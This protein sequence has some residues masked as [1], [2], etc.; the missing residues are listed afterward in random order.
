MLGGAINTFCQ[1]DLKKIIAYGSVSHMGFVTLCL[2]LNNSW[3]LNAAILMM[4]GH[5]FVSSALFILIGVV[6]ERYHTRNLRY[7][8]GLFFALP[9]VGMFLF[10]F[11]LFDIGVPGSPAF[12][13][14]FLGIIGV[15]HISLLLTFLFILPMI[16][17]VAATLILVNRILFSSGDERYFSTINS[18]FLNI[19][20]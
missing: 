11:F 18:I 13:A 8:S 12:F 6:Y 10:I 4:V 14:E 5:G 7:Y 15:T 20:Y 9:S 2:F 19:L 3:G 1:L 16:C 17:G